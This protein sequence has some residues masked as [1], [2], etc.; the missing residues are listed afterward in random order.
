LREKI[1][2]DKISSQQKD[3][4]VWKAS[5]IFSR[6]PITDISPE[7]QLFATLS[8]DLSQFNHRNITLRIVIIQLILQT[9]DLQL[10]FE[11][12]NKAEINFMGISVFAS[13]FKSIRKHVN[14]DDLVLSLHWDAIA[15]CLVKTISR[16]KTTNFICYFAVDAS[17]TIWYS[18]FFDITTSPLCHISFVISVIYLLASYHHISIFRIRKRACSKHVNF[19]SELPSTFISHRLKIK[20]PIYD[21]TQRHSNC[22]QLDGSRQY[23][24]TTHPVTPMP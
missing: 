8:Q 7:N 15:R 5:W 22:L 1:Y 18:Q 17:P 3:G 20:Q 10:Y 12:P 13:H 21:A 16:N 11:W 14:L 6:A 19:D 24:P 2:R 9:N 23:N 4:T